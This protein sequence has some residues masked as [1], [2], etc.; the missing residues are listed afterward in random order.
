[1]NVDVTQATRDP[2][3]ES[4]PSAS[5]RT[6][7]ARLFPSLIW[8]LC[9]RAS[10]S[11][12]VATLLI[13][14]YL[15]F[16]T[17]KA[18]P[19]GNLHTGDTDILVQG[20]RQ[21]LRCLSRGKLVGCGHSPGSLL[22]QVGPFP[23]LQYLP[24]MALIKVGLNNNQVVHALGSI[25]LAAFIASL[26]L[27]VVVA[28]RLRPAFWGPV[29][30]M[31]LIGSSLTYQSTAGF[32]EMLAA[33]SALLAVAAVLWRRP[34][35]IVVAMTLATVGKETLFPFLLLLGLLAGRR[36]EDRLLPPLRVCLPLLAGIGIGEFLNVGFNE[37]RFAADKNLTYLQAILRTPGLERKGS[38]LAALWL[39]PSNGA[40]W[41]WTLAVLVIVAVAVM[42]LVRL[43]RAP[44]NASAWLPPLLAVTTLVAF[45]IGLTDWYTPFGWIT[46]GPRLLVP[47]F[48]ASLLV[49]LYTGGPLLA[50]PM[51]RLLL[52]TPGVIIAAA[53]VV[54]GGWA[55]SGAPWSYWPAVVRLI[56]P[57]GGCP[58]LTHLILQNSLSRYYHCAQQVM[59]RIHP[60]VL[61]AA[62]SQGGGDAL[63]A[64]LILSVAS[65]LLVVDLTGRVRR[66]RPDEASSSLELAV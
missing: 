21:T 5:R 17:V 47:L 27:V 1:M 15:I 40:L 30:V 34:V 62:A 4:V 24:S 14:G 49:I 50:D 19:I 35:L 16:V 63:V 26:V 13:V 12:R 54:A 23:L 59:W 42:A 36:E 9:Q 60:I 25:N 55:Q 32:G 61:Q 64:R 7:Q 57:G 18:A 29:L 31:A 28:K 8:Q 43:G 10:V 41:Y 2:A 52:R 33:F 20:A 44:G 51:R 48:P 3:P 58:S 37:F 53:A 46:Y 45:S 66:R 6:G 38:F 22:S 39:A 65:V 56:Q 11:A